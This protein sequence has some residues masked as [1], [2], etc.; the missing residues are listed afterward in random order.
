MTTVALAAA[1]SFLS[2]AAPAAAQLL[3]FVSAVGNDANTCL[4]Q[5]RP[6]RTLQ[7]AIDATAANGEVR[8]LTRLT[9][10]GA[11]AKSI[12][13]DGAGNT[14]IGTIVVNGASA[15]VTLRRLSLNGT[16]SLGNGINITGAAAVHV[17]ECTVERY[18]GDGIRLVATTASRLYVSNTVSRDNINGSGL[19]VEAGLARVVVEDSRFEGNAIGDGLYLL[20][21]RASVIRSVASG[22]SDGVVVAGGAVN[23]TETTTADNGAGV[24]VIKGVAILTSIV[25]SGSGH[26][27]LLYSGASAEITDSVFTNNHTGIR[28]DGTLYTRRNNTV[29]WNVTD[30][31]G[32]GARIVAPAF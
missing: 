28:Y 25:A 19:R 2:L 26:G 1:L 10:N 13:I 8:L 18:T 14:L 27:L 21:Q 29:N 12:T 16:G 30:Y 11:I 9:G 7:R 17:E 6:C 23:I 31:S 3:T 15:K 32:S 4:V 5:A 24:W 20:A 22:N